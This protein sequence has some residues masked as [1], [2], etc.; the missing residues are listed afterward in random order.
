MTLAQSAMPDTFDWPL[1]SP[2][3]VT[4]KAHEIEWGDVADAGRPV[5]TRRQRGAGGADAHPVRSREA[6]QGQHVPLP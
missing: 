4:V 6:V 3:K 2:I 5:R 1:D